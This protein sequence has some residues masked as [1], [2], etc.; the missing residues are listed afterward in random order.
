MAGQIAPLIKEEKAVIDII[1]DTIAG[2][3]ACFAA[4][5]KFEFQ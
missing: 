2:A 1:D 5:T 4:I 3:K